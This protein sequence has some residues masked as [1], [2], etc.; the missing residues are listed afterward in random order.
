MHAPSLLSVPEVE[1][2]RSLEQRHPNLLPRPDRG[3]DPVVTAVA[4]LVLR[5]GANS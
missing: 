1:V 2:F 4:V 5:P 3:T